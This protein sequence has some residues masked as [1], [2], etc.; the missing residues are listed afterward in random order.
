MIPSTRLAAVAALALLASCGRG[1]S[2]RY[3]DF[4]DLV[5]QSGPAV[6]NISTISSVPDEELAQQDD[7]PLNDFFKKYFSDR[8]APPEPGE[9]APA[10]QA[11]SDSLTMT[12]RA[13]RTT[14]RLVTM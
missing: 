11:Q 7:G 12:S 2:S 9:D 8:D 14:W 3:P 1:S 4:A 13:S 5:E 10:P 6:V